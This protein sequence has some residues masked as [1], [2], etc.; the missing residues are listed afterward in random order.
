MSSR[1]PARPLLPRTQ[2][3]G[4]AGE[5]APTAPPPP[6]CDVP[7][8]AAETP[9]AFAPDR[10]LLA[11]RRIDRHS[12]TIDQGI[13]NLYNGLAQVGLRDVFRRRAM[14]LCQ[15]VESQSHILTG[16]HAR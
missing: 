11:Q 15:D 9:A 14:A 8:V 5:A 4:L 6:A 2:R 3:P 13:D 12:Y 7:S 16:L 1:P 10:P